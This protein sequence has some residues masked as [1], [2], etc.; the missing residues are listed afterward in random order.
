MKWLLV[1]ASLFI[2]TQVSATGLCIKDDNGEM[3][4]KCIAGWNG[5]TNQIAYSGA[6]SA[7]IDKFTTVIAY[8]SYHRHAYWFG[9][10]CLVHPGYPATGEDPAEPPEGCTGSARYTETINVPLATAFQ[11]TLTAATALIN[12]L[13]VY[14]ALIYRDSSTNVPEKID[15]GD[16]C[17]SVTTYLGM[18][19]HWNNFANNFQQDYD[20]YDDKYRKRIFKN[21]FQAIKRLY[22]FYA[23]R[24]KRLMKGVKRE[25]RCDS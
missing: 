3:S 17:R 10:E 20:A 7:M 15:K 1:L 8:D 2:H 5:V 24:M 19:Q 22:G 23:N 21:Y 25:Y 13:Q 16:A 6:L 18:A 11:R 9:F 12:E 14:P 4:Q